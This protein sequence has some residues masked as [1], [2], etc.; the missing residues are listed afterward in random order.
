MPSQFGEFFAMSN[1]SHLIQSGSS[2]K[3]GDPGPS[4][5][6]GAV[7]AFCPTGLWGL[8]LPLPVQLGAPREHFPREGASWD[9]AP[10]QTLAVLPSQPSP[11]STGAAG[12]L[13]SGPSS[14]LAD[15]SVR[16]GGPWD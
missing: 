7:R 4:N 15:L 2:L 8:C 9:R 16:L 10:G 5:T 12:W 14:G 3:A 11:L 1:G 13:L 6:W